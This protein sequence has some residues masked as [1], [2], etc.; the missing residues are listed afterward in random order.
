MFNAIEVPLY[1]CNGTN[2]LTG[3]PANA[4]A[5]E[6]ASISDMNRSLPRCTDKSCRAMEITSIEEFALVGE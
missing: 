2:I 1:Q 3:S 5:T 4:A 6:D